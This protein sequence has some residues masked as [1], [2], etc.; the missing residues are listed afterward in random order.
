MKNKIIELMIRFFRVN[1]RQF[2]ILREETVLSMLVECQH[3]HDLKTD[4]LKSNLHRLHIF[5][6]NKKF[7]CVI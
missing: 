1:R 3:Q 4:E 6:W 5:V 7:C 2:E